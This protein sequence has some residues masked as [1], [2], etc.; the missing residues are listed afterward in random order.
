MNNGMV[1]DYDA[2][3]VGAG[4][5][6]IAA[7]T[8]L[9]AAGLKVIC[10][11]ASGRIG[12]RAHTDTAIFGVPFDTGA[13]WL[14]NEQTNAL[15]APGLALGLNLYLAPE[16]G[17]THGLEDD[18]VLWDEVDRLYDAIEQ[19]AQADAETE[20]ATGRPTDRSLSDLV[21]P[22]TPWSFT[23]VSLL[24]L[25]IAR[26]LPDTSLRDI[27][28]WEGGGDVFCRE[29]FGHLVARTAQGL[30][31][32]LSTPV[33]EIEA[34]PWGVR[35]KT[36]AGEISAR[37]VIV[38]ASVGVLAD[39]VIRFDPPLDADRRAAFEL[40]TMGDYNHVALLFRPGAVPVPPRAVAGFC[41]T[42][43]AR[44]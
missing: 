14:H 2:I 33:T 7:T 11:E 42:F 6:G 19:A 36:T 28:T 5:A 1:L 9:C 44:T 20:I 43:R 3:V 31:I 18:R 24:A 8:A 39:D 22:K 40:I 13:H 4:A 15:K 21:L 29:G 17:V 41:V 16:N 27:A 32:R 37:A 12:G 10:V 23:A 30:P 34:L 26:D 35:V 25:S 38:T